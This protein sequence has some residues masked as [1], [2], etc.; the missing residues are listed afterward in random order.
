VSDEQRVA[1]DAIMAGSAPEG[2]SAPPSEH[3]QG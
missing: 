3:A 2:A 1:I